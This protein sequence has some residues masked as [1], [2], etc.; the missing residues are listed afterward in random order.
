M[1]PSQISI[2]SARQCLRSSTLLNEPG[3]T[4]ERFER[5]ARLGMFVVTH[6]VDGAAPH[7]RAEGAPAARVTS[8]Q[9]EEHAHATAA[10]A[11]PRLDAFHS[12]PRDRLLWLDVP[13]VDGVSAPSCTG[14]SCLPCVQPDA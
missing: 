13:H 6:G 14:A 5:P 2:V 4:I 9:L 1:F 3:F 8:I 10:A 11:P 12:V 7:V